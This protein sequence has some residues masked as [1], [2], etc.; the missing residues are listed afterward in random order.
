MSLVDG[1]RR[2]PIFSWHGTTAEK[3]ERFEAVAKGPLYLV[4]VVL[5]PDS[6]PFAH[7]EHSDDDDSYAG[8][9]KVFWK[10]EEAEKY[11]S[12]VSRVSG[13]KTE[14][15]QIWPVKTDTVALVFI[16]PTLA[17]TVLLASTV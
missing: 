7:L 10:H 3:A 4:F 8:V 2:D 16:Q 14:Q 13:Y 12:D 6:K 15:L 9:G 17:L 1:E 5:S 11:L